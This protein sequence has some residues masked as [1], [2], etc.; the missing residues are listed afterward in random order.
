V[1][2]HQTSVQS[3]RA[4][5]KSGRRYG[6]PPA[7]PPVLEKPIVLVGPPGSGEGVL[8]RALARAGRV[9]RPPGDGMPRLDDAVPSLAAGAN[10]GPPSHRLTADDAAEAADAVRTR[11][12]EALVDRE[13]RPAADVEDEIR[14][15]LFG[16]RLTLRVPFLGAIFP[17]ARFVYLHRDPAESIQEMLVAWQSEQFVSAPALEGWEGPPWSL[18]LIPR[19]RDLNGAPL[20]EIVVEQ[21]RAISETLLDDLEPLGPER[22][23]MADYS[24]MLAHPRR[25]LQRLC[26]FLELHYDQALLSPLEMAARARRPPPP[27]PSELAELLPRAEPQARRAREYLAEAPPTIEAPPPAP[28]A[29]DSPLRSVHTGSMPQMLSRLGSSLLISTYQTGRLVVGRER[30]ALVNTHFRS[31]DKPMG[32]AVAPGRFALGTRTEVWD[33]RNMPEVAPKVEPPGTHDAC[34]L[35]RNRHVTGDIAIHEMAFA[36]RELWIVATAFSCLATLDADHSFVP[37]WKPPWIT[38]L[39]PGDRCHLNGMAVIDERVAY[40]TALGRSDEPGGW[41]EG[42]ATGGVLI[43]VATSEVAV[44]GLSMPHSP[45]WYDGKLWVLESGKGELCTLDLDSGTSEPVAELPGF[46][47]GMT[48]AGGM[49]FIGLSQIRE[50][51]TFGDLPITHRLSERQAGVWAVDLKTGRVAGFLRFEDLVQEVFDVALLPGMRYPEV[52]EPGSSATTTSF[53]LP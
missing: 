44:D 11:L 40:V 35:P 25:E 34:F 4:L 3:V 39:Q 5:F 6:Q 28:G 43:D 17:D 1:I 21:W 27:P 41:R 47:R 45:R 37:R 38:A 49:A 2:V 22:W 53:V 8:F 51:S 18:P 15:L 29:S 12:I 46:T 19:W 30:N 33:F 16:W 13:G 20:E 52:A 14:P 7:M 48:F 36:G 31:F 24:A 10:G 50:S 32:I 9:W 42:K 23:C 26:A